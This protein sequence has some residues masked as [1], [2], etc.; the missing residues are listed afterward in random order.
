MLDG[1][2]VGRV[3][4]VA[5]PAGDGAGYHRAPLRQPTGDGRQ[6]YL[7]YLQRV[8]TPS[9]LDNRLEHNLIGIYLKGPVAALVSN[10]HIVGRQDLRMNERGNGIHLW[11]SP[12]SVVEN[13]EVR[14]GRDGI[15]VTTSRDN[16]FRNNHLSGVRFAIHYMYANDSEV[17]R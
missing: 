17:Q 1:G 9:I 12:G 6:R 3:L 14:L 15:F 11:N 7:R 5:A 16:Q 10:N 4:T 8:T 2:G 13:N